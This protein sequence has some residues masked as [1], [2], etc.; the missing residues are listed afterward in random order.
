MTWKSIS[1][2][3]YFSRYIIWL[4]CSNNFPCFYQTNEILIRFERL[5]KKCYWVSVFLFDCPHCLGG[6]TQMRWE[7]VCLKKKKKKKSKEV[8]FFHN[9]QPVPP[10]MFSVTRL[11]ATPSAPPLGLLYGDRRKEC[12]CIR[13]DTALWGPCCG[14]K[15]LLLLV[16]R[17]LQFR[18]LWSFKVDKTNV[19]ETRTDTVD[20]WRK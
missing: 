5:W 7:C 20:E 19:F 16:R 15:E 3:W 10:W 8:F 2:E 12:L 18:P 17:S 6:G 4:W 13:K 11:P 14:C 9:H 1:K